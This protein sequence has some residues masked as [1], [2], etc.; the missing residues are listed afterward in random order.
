MTGTRTHRIVNPAGRRRAN[1][2]RK[3]KNKMTAKQIRYFGTKAQRSAL[4]RRRRAGASKK[5]RHN[6]ARHRR[7]T[8][9]RLHARAKPRKQNRRRAAHRTRRRSNPGEI[10]SLVLPNRGGRK[11]KKM[12]AH[13]RKK[14]NRVHHRRRNAGH[15]RVHH[16]RRSNPFGGGAVTDL[17]TNSVF[18]IAGAVGSKLLTQAVLGASNV[19]VMGYGG[20]A[21]ATAVLGWAAHSFMRNEKARNAIIAG[22]AVQI[23]LRLIQDYTPF[24]KYAQ[25]TGVG[26][27]QASNFVIPMRA[28]DALNSAMYEVP[29]GWG[30]GQMVAPK[31]MGGLYDGGHSLY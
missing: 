11:G 16:R 21:I 6:V 29:A 24:G 2:R 12:A 30:P 4:K 9:P 22:G 25:L 26:D 7:R 3:R 20:N 28:V 18:I 1:R 14:R 15:R 8:R 27:Y 13:R 5:R 19:G 10:L 31:G 17:L 23:V